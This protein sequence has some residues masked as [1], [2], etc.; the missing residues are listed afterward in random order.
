MDIE[1]ERQLSHPKRSKTKAGLPKAYT[2]HLSLAVLLLGFGLQIC[3]ASAA[4]TASNS[5]K[6]AGSAHKTDKAFRKWVKKLWPSA[7]RKGI[8]HNTFKAAFN[9]VSPDPDVIRSANYQ[10]E[11]VRPVW[12]YIA[13][14]VSDQRIASG[15]DMLSQHKALLDK[16]EK[17]YGVDRHVVVAIW[18]LESNFGLNKGDMSV[19]RSLATL[20]YRDRKRRRFG[21]RQLLSALKILQR[22]DIGIAG[23]KGSWAGAMGHTQFIPTT[24]DA[25]AVDF[26]RDG[27]RDI[28]N[29]IADALGSTAAY[30][31]HSRWKAGQTW[32]YEVKLPKTIGARHA[33]R[34]GRKSLKAWAK[35]GVKRADGAKFPRP[36]DRA[37][38][39]LPA[40]R[41]G[42]AF[43]VINNFHSILRYNNAATYALAVGH[44]SDR[45]RGGKPFSTPWPTKHRPLDKDERIELQHL[46]I[47]KGFDT[48]GT[49][50]II[51]TR[52][53]QAV[54]DYQKSRGHRIDGWP[55][56]KLL[57]KLRNDG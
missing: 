24:F 52:T 37:T 21:R 49:D 30:L 17:K 31:K 7:R 22:G 12:D 53:L 13:S 32:G 51:G 54:R 41:R 28:W 47:K 29:S 3:D 27:R 5:T 45:L 38:L 33:G 2:L 16:I 57:E 14:A 15:R 55:N 44:L 6:T 20:A 9:N 18:G 4:D 35:K 42:P 48:G 10:P 26:D 23:L 11:F 19:I 50:G 34:R 56:A 8:K 39:Y 40:G 36:S 43:L 25:Y 1:P 46:L